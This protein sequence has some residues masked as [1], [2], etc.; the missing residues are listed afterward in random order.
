MKLVGAGS[1][2]NITTA[3][4]TIIIIIS[5]INIS[6]GGSSSIVSSSSS[7]I[8]GGSSRRK[9]EAEEA[10]EAAL[11]EVRSWT[12]GALRE[13]YRRWVIEITQL[14]P[15]SKTKQKFLCPM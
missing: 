10:E 15:G 3:T 7:S 13:G 1:I 8:H 6:I 4:A 5:S 11:E 9:E 2:A 12:V 14:Q